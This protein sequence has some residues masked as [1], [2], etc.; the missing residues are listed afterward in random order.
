MKNYQ[1]VTSTNEELKNQKEELKSQNEYLQK[2][3][4]NNMKQ[5]PKLLE[6]PCGSI[7]GDEGARD[8]VSLS[9]ELEPL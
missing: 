2:Q 1:A 3:L 7:Y 4:G 9:S 8:L 5:K 6:S